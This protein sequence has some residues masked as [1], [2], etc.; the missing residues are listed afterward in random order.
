[1]NDL[2]YIPLPP[3]WGSF[4][5]KDQWAD[6]LDCYAKLMNLNV[7]GSTEALEGSFDEATRLWEVRLRL[8]DG[9]ERVMRPKHVVL[10]VGGV[11][12]RPRIPELPGLAD[13]EGEVLHSSR[14]TSGTAYAGKEVMVVGASTTAH[15]ICLDLHHKGASPTM[16][17]RG[18]T[19]V[20]NIDEVV[21]F[22]ADYAQV[23]VDE[24][25]QL[26]SSMVL[27]LMIKRAQAYT[28][29]TDQ[30]HAELHEGLRQAGQKLTTG[31]DKTGWSIKLFRDAAGY[32]LNVG[33]SEA[34]IEGQIKVLDFDTIERFVPEGALLQDGTVRPL[35]VV[36]LATGFH[37]LSNDIEA[38]FGPAV[39]KKFGRCVGVADD[40]EYRT[41]S[42]P[43]AQ[44]HLWLINGGIVDA[45]K[46][47]DLLAL[48]VIA[49]MEGLA[50]SLVRQPDGS[51]APL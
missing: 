20:V 39:A 16:A 49:Q 22:S 8:A 44:P 35:D 27:P 38:L 28:M 36:V 41:M 45:R 32:Y 33:G 13:F 40:G 11:G 18:P 24:A 48:Q 34:I 12:G 7:W 43:T 6:W 4:T 46:S 42:R 5:P 31:H 10:A 15:D 23:S 21:T 50:P 51:V 19:C 30:T 37:D 17:Q 3:T 14:F 9:S 1:M 47:S 25:D 29:V 2:P 26:R